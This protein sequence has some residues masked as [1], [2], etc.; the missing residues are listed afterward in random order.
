M[1]CFLRSQLQLL[2]SHVSFRAGLVPKE[3]LEWLGQVE[4]Q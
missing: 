2:L 3:S 1:G 4:N